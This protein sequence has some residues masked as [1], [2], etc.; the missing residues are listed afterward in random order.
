MKSRLGGLLLAAL[1]VSIVWSQQTGCTTEMGGAASIMDTVTIDTGNDVLFFFSNMTISQQGSNNCDGSLVL[2]S[3]DGSGTS[4]TLCG[5]SGNLRS[6]NSNS[7]S[8]TSNNSN[9][10]SAVVYMS[11][12]IAS[13][14]MTFTAGKPTDSYFSYHWTDSCTANKNAADCQNAPGCLYCTNGINSG[15]CWSSGTSPTCGD[16]NSVQLS[17]DTNFCPVAKL[18]ATQST[19][20]TKTTTTSSNNNDNSTP[21]YVIGIIVGCCGI[22]IGALVT[23]QIMR[24]RMRE[25]GNK[26][27]ALDEEDT[28][29]IAQGEALE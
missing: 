19:D 25:A 27:V 28:M 16:T 3:S 17:A 14:S 26:P 29:T 15:L 10:A 7:A 11:S 24:R 18:K 6:I 12:S 2:A 8:G 20:N 22:A 1:C 4:V 13:V 23:A 9:V 21:L 5:T